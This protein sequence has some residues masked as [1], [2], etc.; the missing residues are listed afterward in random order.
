MDLSNE[1]NSESVVCV[2]EDQR[3][4]EA[5][6]E[7]EQSAKGSEEVLNKGSE[8]KKG[9]FDEFLAEIGTHESPENKIA[10]ILQFMESALSQGGSPSFKN[11]WEARKRC[12]ALFKDQTFSHAVRTHLWSK[13]VELSKEAHRLKEVLD[14][15]SAFAAEQIKL[16]IGALEQDLEKM[17]DPKAFPSNL[18]FD[19]VAKSVESH[20]SYYIEKQREL[21]LLNAFAARINSLRKELI[22]TDMRIRYKNGFFQQLSKAGDQV[23][24][25]RKELIKEVSQ[26]FIGHVDEFIDQYFSGAKLEQPLYFLRDEIKALQNMAKVLTLNTQSFNQTR[27]KLSECWDRIKKLEKERKKDRTKLHAEFKEAA[28]HVEP[29]LKELEDQFE[30][31]NLDEKQLNQSLQ[32]VN[33]LMSEV[34]LSREDVKKFRE[35]LT[36]IRRH[37]ADKASALEKERL[38]AQRKLEEERKEQYAKIFSTLEELVQDV[39]GKS[40]DEVNTEWDRIQG[41]FNQLTLTKW[42]KHDIERQSKLLQDQLSKLKIENLSSNDREAF[43]Q[44]QELLKEC[45]QRRKE[46]RNQLEDFR[47]ASGSSGLDFE[48]ALKQSELVEQEKLRLSSVDDEIANIESRIKKLS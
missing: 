31:S 14:E 1:E 21:S 2:A 22:K 5:N 23:F 29:T 9:A 32:E 28:E 26:Q 34:R 17:S 12:L 40:V 35:R 8:K 42:E 39:S 48:Q 46:I 44:L 10:Y 20:E 30:S 18:K 43:D 7:N 11:F 41:E 37:V 36:K 15:Q 19:P 33:R 4:V 3:G 27:M 13:Y 16:A 45:K 38:E 6:M 47:K 24:P 25:Q